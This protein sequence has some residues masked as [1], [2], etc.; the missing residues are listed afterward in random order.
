MN[1]RLQTY[2]TYLIDSRKHE[3]MGWYNHYKSIISDVQ[4]I[5][6]NLSQYS[7]LQDEAYMNTSFAKHKTPSW[8]FFK[9]FFANKGN[10]IASNGRS[11]LSNNDFDKVYND[12]AFVKSVED[13]IKEP[14]KANHFAFKTIWKEKIGN[15]NP[16]LT[17]RATAACGLLVTSTVDEASFSQVFH[18]LQEQELIANYTGENNWYDQNVFVMQQLKEVLKDVEDC[19]EYWVSIFY[20]EM[21]E[22]LT[23]PFSLKKQ[24]VKYGAPGTGKTYIAKEVAKLQFKIWESSFIK[25]TGIGFNDCIETIQF[26]PSYSYEDFIE[27]LR[28]NL[29]G[30]LQLENGIFKNLCK[31]AAKW[32][33]DV[34]NIN[35]N[36]EFNT[37]KVKDV[38]YYKNEL[39]QN[40]WTFV[41]SEN[42]NKLLKDIIAPYFII[43]DE[44]N[45]AELSRVF[46][47]L[48]YCLEYRGINGK[49]KTQYSQLNSQSTGM[50]QINNESYFFVPNNLY[51]MGT[52]NTVDRSVESFD[53]ALRRRFK[54]EEVLPNTDLLRYHLQDYNAK[55]IDLA[56]NLQNLNEAIE[57]EILLG[58]DYCIGHAYLW[59]L[60]YAKKL[61]ITEVRKTVWDDS[62]VSLLEEYLRGTGRNDLLKT[63]A[64]S[65]GL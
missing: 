64:K 43:I 40:Y 32:E 62:I 29:E 6:Q 36:L 23:K 59:E 24:I 39:S 60:P 53:F 1:K 11:I 15:N 35:P 9:A 48:M 26:H 33:I 4:K 3:R 65:F 7:L 28:P 63:F 55:W 44:I 16:V 14:S 45:R 10:G 21:Y 54:W 50:L 19:D 49:V 30:K 13:L 46:G 25:D 61:P 57:N 31:R 37:L 17:N 38:L 18:W 52:M 12:D 27:G 22:N 58:K 47:E 5:K 42:E 8:H 41:F 20:W 56:D 51:V 34:F 2:Y